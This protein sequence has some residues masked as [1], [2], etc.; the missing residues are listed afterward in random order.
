LG[1]LEVNAGGL[2][3]E[4]LRQRGH[5]GGAQSGTQNDWAS[6]REIGGSQSPGTSCQRRCWRDRRSMLSA[7]VR[8]WC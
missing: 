8:R 6:K 4:V 5:V 7:Q 1:E 3:R 2:A